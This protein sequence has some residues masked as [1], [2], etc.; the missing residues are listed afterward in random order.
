[1]ANLTPLRV[2]RILRVCDLF[3]GTGGFSYG[4]HK[5]EASSSRFETVFAHDIEK[6]SKVIYDTNFSQNSVS[7]TLGDIHDLDPVSI[8]NFDVLTAGF[9]CQPFSVSG[10]RRGFDDARSNTFWKL[11]EIIRIKRPKYFILEN[12]K[13]LQSHDEGKTFKTITENLEGIEGSPSAHAPSGYRLKYK[14]LNTC[15][16]TPFPQNRERIYIVGFD[17]T[18]VSQ[19]QIERFE[20]PGTSRFRIS[21]PD[22]LEFPIDRFLAWKSAPCIDHEMFSPSEMSTLACSFVYCTV[23]QQ[24]QSPQ[25]F[26]PICETLVKE[27]VKDIRETDSE[28]AGAVYQYR[29]YYVRENK[30]GLCPTLTANMGTGGH[31]VPIILDNGVIRK[32]TPRECFNLQG[33]GDDYILP[34]GS[35]DTPYRSNAKLYKLAGNAISPTIAYEIG[36]RFLEIERP[37]LEIERPEGATS[38]SDRE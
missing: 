23:A 37:T 1:M 21:I 29:R 4:L 20:F 13:N 33:F 5:C 26:P 18:R 38:P 8:P 36:M 14:V 30:S 11:L 27:V 19:E 35:P 3:A 22:L 32:L 34:S 28:T 31:N 24:R 2:P 9:P 6:S 17:A 25:A 16:V 15:N 7:L 12:V 10:L